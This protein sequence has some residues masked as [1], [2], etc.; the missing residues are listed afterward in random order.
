MSVWYV[1]Q[2]TVS[3]TQWV[4]IQIQRPLRAYIQDLI[5]WWSQKEDTMGITL[6]VLHI[7]RVY[8]VLMW[9]ISCWLAHTDRLVLLSPNKCSTLLI[10]SPYIILYTCISLLHSGRFATKLWFCSFFFNNPYNCVYYSPIQF[11][12]SHILKIIKNHIKLPKRI[13]S[14]RPIQ[15]IYMHSDWLFH[16]TSCLY[17]TPLS[18]SSPS[19]LG[20]RCS[21]CSLS[22][23][24]F[25]NG[26]QPEEFTADFPV[27]ITYSAH[28][29]QQYNV[30]ATWQSIG[31]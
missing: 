1:E 9:L 24:N 6:C 18:P 14:S 11:P 20:N 23:Y 15:N 2:H 17:A 13:I 12:L 4:D 26:L 22:L 8:I 19:T 3:H 28:N 31:K 27:N 25:C 7:R 29:H 5:E 16:S 10:E 21:S 30:T